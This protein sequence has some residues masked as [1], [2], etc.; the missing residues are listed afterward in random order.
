M[1]LRAATGH[2][3]PVAPGKHTLPGRCP[4]AHTGTM[5]GHHT[6]A[7]A[8]VPGHH[9]RAPPGLGGTTPQP[10]QPCPPEG[11]RLESNA[12]D[13][14]PQGSPPPHTHKNER[15]GTLNDEKFDHMKAARSQTTELLPIKAATP[16][17][18]SRRPLVAVTSAPQHGHGW[19]GRS[20]M[21]GD[22]TLLGFAGN[23]SSPR[24][25][26]KRVHGLQAANAKA[27]SLSQ[28]TCPT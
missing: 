22:C 14:W 19:G 21:G 26:C 8:A 7:P 13:G 24:T 16:D 17:L 23:E 18:P 5:A 9:T 28:E 2:H 10:F 15:D 27:T 25:R 4:T 1:S 3:T 20:S 11:R 6:H 12:A